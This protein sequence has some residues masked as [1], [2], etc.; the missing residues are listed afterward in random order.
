MTGRKQHGKN[1][2]ST[3]L[4]YFR[5][6]LLNE[7]QRSDRGV[8]QPSQKRSVQLFI[9]ICGPRFVYSGD[10]YKVCKMSVLRV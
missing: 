10:L 1:S 9:A 2:F 4:F 8:P 6:Y 7:R 5:L 3:F